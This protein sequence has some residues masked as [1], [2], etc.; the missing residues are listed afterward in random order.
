MRTC[1]VRFD[2]D[3]FV[4]VQFPWVHGPP[5]LPMQIPS[6]SSS[7][8]SF[9]STSQ[10]APDLRHLENPEPPE[11]PG[12]NCSSSRAGMPQPSSR[13]RRKSQDAESGLPPRGRLVVVSN[14]LVDPKQPAAGGLA[15][16]LGGLMKE[17]PGLW[18]GWSGNINDG[19]APAADKL[20]KLPYGETTLVPIDL[21]Q[22]EHDHYYAGF[23]NKVLWPVFHDQ[24]QHAESGA[25]A[26]AR[27]FESYE[28]VNKKFAKALAGL[29]EED[30]AIWVHDYHLIPLATELRRLGCRQRIGFFNHIPFPTLGALSQIPQHGQLVSSLFDYDLVGMQAQRDLDRFHEYVEIRGQG[31]R[32]GQ[33][34]VQAFGR[35]VR[36]QSFPIG[37]DAAQFTSQHVVADE[38]KVLPRMRRERHKRV[39]MVAV[40]RLDYTKGLQE[41]LEA[42]RL[43]LECHPECRRHVTL[44]QVVSPSRESVAAYEKVRK[45]V[46]A[47]VNALNEDYG[48]RDW[49][50]V[51]HFEEVVD[52]RA[53]P[54]FFRLGRVGVVTSVA[55]GMNLVA[56]EYVAAQDPELPGSLVLS[57]ATGAAAQLTEALMVD[58]KN[59][60]GMAETFHRALHL[61][62]EERLERHAAM[63]EN[64]HD[65]NLPR[66][67]DSYLDA[68]EDCDPPPL[69]ADA[70]EA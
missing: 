20:P 15:A 14:R 10:S 69:P 16:A 21:S 65:Q 62:L 51:L 43:L 13:I 53:L 32:S 19:P 46:N 29:L 59:P 47:M 45:E 40:D 60:A 34:H 17:T 11:S 61:P 27:F 7:S 39:L 58:P 41:R 49:T 70:P 44:A 6:S 56:K 2:A 12:G 24:V 57:S 37:I 64:V 28:Q 54:E 3:R 50:P 25:E 5:I 67:S 23:A 33:G 38:G 36:S 4:L 22:A 63:L 48:S 31:R 1:M 30:D 18:L 55:D 9:L 42:F 35:M 26:N 52:R 8:F 68:L 66:W